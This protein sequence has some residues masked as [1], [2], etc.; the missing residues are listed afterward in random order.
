MRQSKLCKLRK[1]KLFLYYNKSENYPIPSVYVKEEYDFL[2]KRYI[3][4]D[5]HLE[6]RFLI[7]GSALVFIP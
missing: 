4:F 1:G 2:L 7:K 3:C 5:V 6:C